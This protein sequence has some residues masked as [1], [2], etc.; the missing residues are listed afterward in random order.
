MNNC[1]IKILFATFYFIFEDRSFGVNS[2]KT[3]D[4][5]AFKFME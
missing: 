3:L 1:T 5:L 2:N 4:L